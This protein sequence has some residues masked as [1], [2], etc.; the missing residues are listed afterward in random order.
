MEGMRKKE[1][2]GGLKK[3]WEQAV[4]GYFRG[5]DGTRE[6]TALKNGGFQEWQIP[7]TLHGLS[8]ALGLSAREV[9]S[10]GQGQA[11]NRW[12]QKLLSQSISRIAAYTMERALLGELSYQ[13]ALA[14]LKELGEESAEGVNEGITV[15][16]EAGAEV[17]S[18]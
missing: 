8:Y 13:V 3:Q 5:C 2:E 11:G 12:Q 9:L 1:E 14:A 17:Y 6:R 15:T 18:R 16:M 10:I 7:Y 4:E